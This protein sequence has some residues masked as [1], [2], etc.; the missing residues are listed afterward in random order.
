[1]T[2]NDHAKIRLGIWKISRRITVYI[3]LRVLL[4]KTIDAYTYLDIVY[5]EYTIYTVH[6][7]LYT[8]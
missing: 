2:P 8:F 4:I 1:M 7:N 3:H 5:T 6:I